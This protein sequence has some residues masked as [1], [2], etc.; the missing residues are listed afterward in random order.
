M[1]LQASYTIIDSSNCDRERE[2]GRERGWERERERKRE[3]G[4]REGGREER[5]LKQG[6]VSGQTS[7]CVH[8]RMNKNTYSM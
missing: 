6:Y 8:K 7:E 5:I 4:E 3:R 1:S 2:G